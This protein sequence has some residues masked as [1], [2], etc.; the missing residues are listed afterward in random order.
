[1]ADRFHVGQVCRLVLDTDPLFNGL[2]GAFCTVNLPRRAGDW[3]VRNPETGQDEFATE[4]RYRVTLRTGES[5][6]VEE[7][8]LRPL[9]DGEKKVSWERFAKRIGVDPR[10]KPT[11][12]GRREA[13]NG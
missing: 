9:Y 7:D 10:V 4:P 12:R 6:N 2:H 3:L 1:M 11:K 8:M 5:L 13:A